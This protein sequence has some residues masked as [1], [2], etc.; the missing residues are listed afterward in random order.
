MIMMMIMMIMVVIYRDDGGLASC[1]CIFTLLALYS[2]RRRP[3]VVIVAY[4]NDA[5]LDMDEPDDRP[6][7][8]A[9]QNE[10]RARARVRVYVR[11]RV[12]AA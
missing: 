4:S 10:K 9:K 7:R 3:H 6:T 11:K 8:V 5:A 2:A 1:R 12:P